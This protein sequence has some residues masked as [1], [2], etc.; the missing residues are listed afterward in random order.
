[1]VIIV[2]IL[3]LV[4]HSK[5][6]VG[7]MQHHGINLHPSLGEG[8]KF[9]SQVGHLAKNFGIVQT[10]RLQLVEVE[11]HQ[12]HRQDQLVRHQPQHQGQPHQAHHQVPLQLEEALQSNAEP[13]VARKLGN[14]LVIFPNLRAT[15]I[16]VAVA[17]PKIVTLL[18]VG[19]VQEDHPS[20]KLH[21]ETNISLR[22]THGACT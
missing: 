9:A 6:Q 20:T 21:V 5:V 16:S 18:L 19:V 7:P 14:G 2:T 17:G 11:E 13:N 4:V 10:S 3:D 15:T 1:M 22:M 8:T 12:A